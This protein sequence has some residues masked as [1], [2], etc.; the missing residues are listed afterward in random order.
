MEFG[1]IWKIMNVQIITNLTLLQLYDKFF[2]DLTRH[3][4]SVGTYRRQ[5]FLI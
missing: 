5:D 4:F 3:F 1:V 2:P